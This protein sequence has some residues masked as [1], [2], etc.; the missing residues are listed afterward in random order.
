[1]N[2][3]TFVEDQNAKT[4][5]LPDGWDSREKIALDLDCS[6]DSVRKLMGPAIKTGCVETNVFPVWDKLTKRIVRMTA[7]RKVEKKPSKPVLGHC[8][9]KMGKG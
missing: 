4:Y 8:S 5:R 3:K 1:M 6:P 7:Y 2:W 9:G